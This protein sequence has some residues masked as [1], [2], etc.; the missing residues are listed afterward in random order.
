MNNKIEYA[1]QL[2]MLAQRGELR[3]SPD[4]SKVWFRQNNKTYKVLYFAM[5]KIEL[6]EVATV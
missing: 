3:I 1:C 4:M 5:G 6:R 2:I